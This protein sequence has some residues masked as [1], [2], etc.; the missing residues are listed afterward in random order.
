[1]GFLLSTFATTYEKS[2]VFAHL[3]TL[4]S[5]RDIRRVKINVHARKEPW[6][7]AWQHLESGELAQTTWMPQPHE[8]L[9]RATNATWQPTQSEN[10]GDAYRDVH[11]AYQLSVRWLI[12]GITSYA[13]H[14]VEIMNGWA[15]TLR[16]INGTE[17]KFLA[18]GLYG[19]QIANAA[20]L[21]GIYSGWTTANQSAFGD[22]LS[23]IREVKSRI[24]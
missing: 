6:Y 16:N 19:H 21:L 20:E 1:M 17:D 3:C 24:S 13:D 18:A 22:M 5:E 4:Y 2:S 10:Y 8:I 23:N 7:R 9:V 15:S 12:G 11:S 14:A